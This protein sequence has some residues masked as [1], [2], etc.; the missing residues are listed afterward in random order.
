MPSKFSVSDYTGALRD[1]MP[2]GIAWPKDVESVQ[3]QLLIAFAKQF[4]KNDEDAQALIKGAFPATALELLP[5]WEETLGLPDPC[6]I[7]EANTI[8]KRR[9]AII[10]KLFGTGSLS[11]SYFI[12]LFETLG[13]TIV[14][15]EYRQ[16][17]AGLSVCGDALNGGDWPFTWKVTAPD[18]TYFPA[19]AG[20][21]F[22]GD[23]LRSG[24]NKTLAC[25]VEQV[26]PSHNIYI[27]ELIEV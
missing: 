6:S 23:P 15:T 8:D 9:N 16:A 12:K 1:L 18:S 20:K 13:Y 21:S 24:G 25:K 3:S 17:R 11:K 10:A 5:E 2:Q 4:Q 22:C 14:I 7:S 19:K 27:L 26:N